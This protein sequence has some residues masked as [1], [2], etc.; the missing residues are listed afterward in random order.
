MEQSRKVADFNENR[1]N[2]N[3]LTEEEGTIAS[4]GSAFSVFILM[5]DLID[6]LKLLKYESEFTKEFN[7]KLLPKYL[8]LLCHSFN[9]HVSILSMLSKISKVK[10]T[11]NT[12]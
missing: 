7:I 11:I 3:D 1:R 4:P 2:S 12:F 8:F 6:K 9:T 5:E 10:T